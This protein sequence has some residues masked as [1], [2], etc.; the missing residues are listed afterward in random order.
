[1]KRIANRKPRDPTP[2]ERRTESEEHHSQKRCMDKPPVTEQE[3]HG[4]SKESE[5]SVDETADPAAQ[6][7]PKDFARPGYRPSAVD[8]RRER[9]NNQR[10]K[11]HGRRCDTCKSPERDRSRESA[12]YMRWS[13]HP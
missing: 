8:I 3:S 10:Q 11:L 6:E 9:A 12:Y 1:M 5:D 2:L 7:R 13:G 4:T